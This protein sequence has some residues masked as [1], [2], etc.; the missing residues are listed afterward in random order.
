MR[1]RV[2]PEIEMLEKIQ[3]GLVGQASAISADPLVEGA[4]ARYVRVG[5]VLALADVLLVLKGLLESEE[6]G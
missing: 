1:D 4:S 2:A 5:V 3:D 6:E